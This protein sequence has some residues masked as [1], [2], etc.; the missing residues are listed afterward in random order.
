MPSELRHTHP[1]PCPPLGHPLGDPRVQQLHTHSG[2]V[3]AMSLLLP[4]ASA[5]HH[6]SQLADEPAPPGVSLRLFCI[7]QDIPMPL[8]GPESA[9]YA[10]EHT[11]LG[12]QVREHC[13]Q[14]DIP[15]P[16]MGSG[17]AL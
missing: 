11:D 6:T 12:L 8:V 7:Q 5:G 15:M 17:S 2:W 10:V 1:G 4:V 13:I 3:P 16:V 14:W 9:L